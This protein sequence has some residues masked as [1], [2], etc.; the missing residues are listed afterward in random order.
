MSARMSDIPLH[1]IQ[2]LVEV[3]DYSIYLFGCAV[4]AGLAI[5]AV[6]LIVL[7]RRWRNRRESERQR[8]YRQL[9]SL[10]LSDPKQAA[11]AISRLGRFFA[12]DSERTAKGYHNL[13]ER[14]EPYKYAKTVDSIDEETLGYYRLY[15]EM[16]DV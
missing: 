10:D 15:L 3:P 13:F 9:A 14:L 5:L 6:V 2:P 7:M 16:I 1:D 11:Y 4:L 8:T 12:S